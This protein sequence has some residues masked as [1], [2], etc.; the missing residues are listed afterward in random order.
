MENKILTEEELEK[1]IEFEYNPDWHKNENVC[2]HFCGK[3]KSVKY[4]VHLPNYFGERALTVNA[5][6]K[7]VLQFINQ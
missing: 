7:C 6:N 4:K 2:C 1:K 5:C 3:T